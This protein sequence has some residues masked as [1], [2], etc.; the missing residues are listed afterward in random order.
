MGSEQFI[1]GGETITYFNI[2]E[3]M[4]FLR[5][6]LFDFLRAYAPGFTVFIVALWIAIF[7]TAILLYIARQSKNIT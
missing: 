3:E 4:G 7:A 2:A 1:V 6:A 5:D